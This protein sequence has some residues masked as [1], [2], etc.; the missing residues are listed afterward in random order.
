MFVMIE[1]RRIELV[2][3]PPPGRSVSAD[4]CVVGAGA[5]GIAA[6]IEASR[7]GLRVCLLDA[8][9]EIGGQSVN[10]LIGT[11]C[12]FYSTGT[13][14]YQLT[15]GFADEMLCE[16]RRRNALA[17]RSGRNSLVAL[18]DETELAA[19]YA[20]FLREAGVDVILGAVIQSVS[21]GA[22]RIERLLAHTRYGA[23]EVAAQT[24]IDASGDAV[25]AAFAGA[26]L[27][28]ADV[29]VY[30]TSMFA[31]EGVGQPVPPRTEI[32]ARLSERAEGYGLRRK[33]GFVFAFPGRD[34]CLVN[35]NHYQTP[36]DAVAMTARGLDARGDIDRALRF[37]AEEFPAAFGKARI[38]SVGQPGVRQT[39]GVVGRRTLRTAD[40]RKGTRA[41][42]AIARSAWPIEFHGSEE[43][44]YWEELPAGHLTWIPLSCMIAAD[45]RNLIAAG[46]CVDAE[47]FALAA[48]RVIGPCMAMGAAAAAAALLGQGDLH[49]VDPAAVQAIVADNLSRADPAPVQTI[50]AEQSRH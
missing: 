31:I 7:L 27:Q 2:A 14:P 50:A 39:R 1:P 22:D 5:A 25:V 28:V 15:Y 13:A 17:H 45:L 48:I 36:L 11:F 24:F 12:G 10:G 35:L 43:G 4:V 9:P 18:Y 42:D 30:G 41:D 46:R 49:A 38:R 33:D 47:P 32:I 8:L 37:L 6:A 23:V 44:V 20:Q 40:V 34:V 3:E 19:V 21:R 29:P 26:R 16:L